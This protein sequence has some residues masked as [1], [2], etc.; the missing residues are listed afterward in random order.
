[1]KL[2]SSMLLVSRLFPLSKMIEGAQYCS[3]WFVSINIVFVI[4]KLKL[5]AR[6]RAQCLRELGAHSEGQV[7]VSS[8][9]MADDNLSHDFSSKYPIS[10]SALYKN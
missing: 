3:V 4:L 2:H 10:S 5:R 6:E 9:H 8:K 7:S 1:M